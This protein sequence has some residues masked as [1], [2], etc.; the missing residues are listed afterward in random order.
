[1][2]GLF[3]Y[4]ASDR[5]N[6]FVPRLDLRTGLDYAVNDCLTVGFSYQLNAWFNVATVDNP[7]IMLD[8]AEWLPDHAARIANEDVL[9]HSFMVNAVWR[10]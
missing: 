10:R 9:T 7:D 8:A 1:V 5:Q 2:T 4:S 3:N 6:N